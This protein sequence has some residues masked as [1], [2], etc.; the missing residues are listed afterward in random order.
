MC[1][2]VEMLRFCIVVLIVF[3]VG[4]A[5]NQ[6]SPSSPIRP[7]SKPTSDPAGQT[8]PPG[9]LPPSTRPVYNLTG[10]PKATQEGYVDGCETAKQTVYGYKDEKRYTADGQ[11]QMGWDDG[12]SICRGTR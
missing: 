4:C 10:Y 9:P 2:G 3:L 5:T 12:F 7:I 8:R 1:E 11:Y 6:Y